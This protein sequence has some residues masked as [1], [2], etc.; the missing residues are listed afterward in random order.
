[1]GDEVETTIVTMGFDAADPAGLLEVLAKYVVMARGHD[2]CRNIDLCGSVSNPGRFVIIS[3]W[4]S[5]AAQRAHFD[6]PDMIE[7]ANACN[8]LLV[9]PP[10]ID[11]L[12]GLSAHDLA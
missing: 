1:M 5:P 6:S 3:K 2:G 9:R 10:D 12:E 7:M 4:G 8:G 11:L